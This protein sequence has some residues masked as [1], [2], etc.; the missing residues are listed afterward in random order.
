[1][2]QLLSIL[3]FFV[4]L[5]LSAQCLNCPSGT[6]APGA[7]ASPTVKFHGFTSEVTKYDGVKPTCYTPTAN[8]LNGHLQG[9]NN[10]LCQ[11]KSVIDSLKTNDSSAFAQIDSIQLRIDSIVT[12]LGQFYNTSVI[13][14]DS[15]VRITVTTNPMTRV[16]TFNLKV[17]DDSVG[18]T[19]LNAISG[20]GQSYNPLKL[21]GALTENTTITGNK[22]FNMNS[23]IF[24]LTQNDPTTYHDLFEIKQIKN[25]TQN[26]DFTSSRNLGLNAMKTSVVGNGTFNLQSLQTVLQ[27]HSISHKLNLSSSSIISKTGD[28]VTIGYGDVDNL[29]LTFDGQNTTGGHIT[30]MNNVVLT[31]IYNGTNTLPMSVYKY[32]SLAI[33]DLTQQFSAS[34][35]S[36][37]VPTD[38]YAIYQEGE[39]DKVWL[40]SAIIVAPNLPIYA[41]DAAAVSDTAFPSGGLYKTTG[42]VALK[43]K[44]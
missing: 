13:S 42:S 34:P 24:R 5:N 31:P 39:L 10:K 7:A 2:K 20:N 26:S 44:P 22:E 30:S 35:S 40:N 36:W 19:A 37:V 3:S 11:L 29:V 38:K 41:N 17:M 9:I 27:A 33:M 43:V 4:C 8:T 25:L 32:T 23:Y 21:G 12:A 15:S 18:V 28:T 1:M 6:T 14:S 16:N